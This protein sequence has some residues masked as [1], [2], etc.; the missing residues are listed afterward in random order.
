MLSEEQELRNRMNRA[1]LI[2]NPRKI[3]IITGLY[4]FSLSPYGNH[5]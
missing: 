4:N 1:E 2:A 5:D 3:D